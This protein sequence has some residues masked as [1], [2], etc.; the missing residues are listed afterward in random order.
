MSNP[1]KTKNRSKNWK[2]GVSGLK[3]LISD[4]KGALAVLV[5]ISAPVFIGGLG[6]GGEVSYWYFTQRKLQNAS[7]VSAYAAAISIAAGRDETARDAAALL[8]AKNGGFDEPIGD[9]IINEPPT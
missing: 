1:A 7:D 3:S 6:L 8:A 2:T 4:Q 5:A 9:I